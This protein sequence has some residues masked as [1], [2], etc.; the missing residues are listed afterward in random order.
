[1]LVALGVSCIAWL[2]VSSPFWMTRA[3][4]ATQRRD[5]GAMGTGG[6]LGH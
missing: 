3:E 6:R 2:M 1:M 5:L 4:M